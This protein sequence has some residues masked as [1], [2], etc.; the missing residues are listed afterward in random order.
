MRTT[1]S[2]DEDVLLAAK[3][4]AAAQKKTAGEV[5]SELARRGLRG[6][7]ESSSGTRN[8]FELLSPSGKLVTAELVARLLEEEC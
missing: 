1:L 8:G 7:A 2:I 6:G 3:E 5:I 4:L